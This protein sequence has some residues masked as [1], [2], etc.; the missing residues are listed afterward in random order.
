MSELIQEF[1]KKYSGLRYS[2][3]IKRRK[4]EW[5]FTIL[6]KAFIDKT[7]SLMLIHMRDKKAFIL[8]LNTNNELSGI[9]PRKNGVH[10][11]GCYDL[12]F[13]NVGN[14]IIDVKY[15]TSKGYKTKRISNCIVEVVNI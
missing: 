14:N 7:L 13:M 8:K 10:L 4:N 5:W 15:I 11:S 2:N 9:I 6:P 3:L 1:K 12:Y